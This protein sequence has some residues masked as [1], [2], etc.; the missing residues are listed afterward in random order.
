[1]APGAASGDPRIM[2]TLPP[3]RVLLVDDSPDF[4]AAAK[5]FVGRFAEL[6]FAGWAANAD[7]AFELLRRVPVDVVLMDTAM[8]ETDGFEATRRIKAQQHP[9][10]VVVV[11]LH[12]GFEY[13]AA[14]RDAG[15][16]GFVAKPSL[17]SQL[18]PLLRGLS[19]RDE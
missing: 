13:R 6:E 15:A 4:A 11:T 12:D 18:L 17:G 16:D 3:L 14:A 19:R 1:M 8:P 2:S 5:E 9:P 10:A 7:E